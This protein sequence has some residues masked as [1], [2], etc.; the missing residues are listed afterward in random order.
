MGRVLTRMMIGVV[1]VSMVVAACGDDPSPDAATTTAPGSTA[2]GST[3]PG[4]S[5]ATSSTSTTTTLPGEVVD[6][7]PY[8]GDELGVV[9]V[10]ADDSLNVRSGPGAGFDIVSQLDPLTTG[11]EA[12]GHNRTVGD[13]GVWSEVTAN[14]VTG[15]ASATY[16][17]QLGRIDDITTE[18]APSPTDRPSAETMLELGRM[19]AGSR[20]S[21][22][23][24]S[25]IVVSGGPEVG[26][27][28]EITV[29]VIGMGDDA[30]LGERLHIF[31]EPDPGGESFTMRTVERT[32][33][34]ARGVTEDGEC[35]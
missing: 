24:P 31:G 3:T 12:T 32:L 10:K 23:P 5:S 2:T 15:W 33:L 35:V 34:C 17:A 28:G 13:S 14:G 11:I 4:D 7:F 8:A 27:L 1:A 20:A 9:G 21:T 29:D 30:I 22:D 19:I 6:L 16:L 25:D 26:D 18:I